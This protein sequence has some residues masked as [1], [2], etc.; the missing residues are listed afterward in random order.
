MARIPW[1]PY[2]PDQAFGHQAALDEEL[3]DRAIARLDHERQRAVLPRAGAKAMLPGA[4]APSAREPFVFG[5]FAADAG[6]PVTTNVA[7]DAAER[8]RS[9]PD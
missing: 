3:L 2:A 9:E 6:L 4:V 8:L 7:L 5:W 1:H